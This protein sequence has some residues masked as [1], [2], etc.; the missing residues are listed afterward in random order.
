MARLKGAKVGRRGITANIPGANE[1]HAGCSVERARQWQSFYT[2]RRACVACPMAGSFLLQPIMPPCPRRPAL[3]A[4]P[5]NHTVAEDRRTNLTGAGSH[6]WPGDDGAEAA[7]SKR[8]RLQQGIGGIMDLLLDS[9]YAPAREFQR[10][11]EEAQTAKGHALRSLRRLCPA[12][13]AYLKIAVCWGLAGGARRA[14]WRVGPALQAASQP[15]PSLQARARMAWLYRGLL[16]AF[17]TYAW[18]NAPP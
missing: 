7:R 9:P 12:E 2:S 4:R 5:L 11:L 8:R 17:T 18:V 16:C 15:K 3:C 1:T 14:C 6:H 13:A 10:R